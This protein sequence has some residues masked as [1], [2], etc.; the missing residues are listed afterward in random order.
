MSF[1]ALKAHAAA[2]PG[3]TVD[4]KWE[5]GWAAS[6]SGLVSRL[7]ELVLQRLPK[8]LQKDLLS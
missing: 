6:D 2:L 8:K 4:I 1:A 5:A 7:H 3:A